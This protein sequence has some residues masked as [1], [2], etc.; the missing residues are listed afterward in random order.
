MENERVLRQ[1][2]TIYH[3]RIIQFAIVILSTFNY[4]TQYVKFYRMFE[5]IANYYRVL[6]YAVKLQGVKNDRRCTNGESLKI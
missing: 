1:V 5:H 2:L 3:I 4:R 6:N